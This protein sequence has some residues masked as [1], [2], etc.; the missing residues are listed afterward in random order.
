MFHG[1][2]KFGLVKNFIKRIKILLTNQESY[3]INGWKAFKYLKL[4]EGAR[5]GDPISAYLFI[6]VL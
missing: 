4:K 3:K 2:E 5:Q 1:L 6:L